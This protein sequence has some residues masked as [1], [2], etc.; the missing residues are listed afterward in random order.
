MKYL[1]LFI[2][3]IFGC[4]PHVRGYEPDSGSPADLHYQIIEYEKKII[5]EEKN[6]VEA[7]I[8]LQVNKEKLIRIKERQE[9]ER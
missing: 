4:D 7:R 1:C 3:L 2:V 6:L 8:R 9:K 5:R